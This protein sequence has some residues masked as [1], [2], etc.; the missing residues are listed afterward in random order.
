MIIT[1]FNSL[2]LCMLGNFTCFFLSSADL[3]FQNY[4]LTKR[5]FQEHY[6]SVV[7]W[8]KTVRKGCC[9][10]GPNCLQ[11]LSADNKSRHK[12]GKS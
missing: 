2:T 5:F 10:L 4:L 9:E 11:R 6:Q 8:V 12:K 1:E 7:Y 3:C